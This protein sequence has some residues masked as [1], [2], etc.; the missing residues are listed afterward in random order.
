[1]RL[2]RLGDAGHLR[3]RRHLDVEVRRDRAPQQLH[4]AVLDVPAVAAEMDGDPLRSG[5]LA[6][7]RRRHRLRLVALPRL[8]DRGDVID[9]HG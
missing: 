3:R 2:Q 4:V 5:E 9:V 1:M 6:Q 7:H 8:A